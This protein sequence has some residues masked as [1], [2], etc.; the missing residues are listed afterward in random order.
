M[1]LYP[2]LLRACAAYLAHDHVYECTTE[3][4]FKM[5]G[6]LASQLDVWGDEGD[7][8][9]LVT[10]HI[11]AI[12]RYGRARPHGVTAKGVEATA[13]AILDATPSMLAWWC[14]RLAT[15]G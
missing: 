5:F 2:E 12:R 6:K 7:A 8:R 9:D 11:D 4:T 1:K 14:E 13:R 10:A 3:D 15:D